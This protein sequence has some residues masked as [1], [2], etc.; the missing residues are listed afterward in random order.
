MILILRVTL[1]GGF[2]IT[3]EVVHARG[4][5]D[6]LCLW[7]DDLLEG[8]EGTGRTSA[9][10]LVPVIDVATFF[11]PQP[12]AMKAVQCQQTARDETAPE[13][14]DPGTHRETSHGIVIVHTV[15]NRTS[16]RTNLAAFR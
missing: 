11:H 1:P 9:R 16:A 7:L 12:E 10:L 6:M 15:S 4:L 8:H 3:A 14:E 5:N 2:L 13:D